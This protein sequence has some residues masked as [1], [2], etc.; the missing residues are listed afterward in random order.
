M[1][2]SELRD[3]VR[4]Y[5]HDPSTAPNNV[6]SDSEIN[7][8]LDR[9]YREVASKIARPLPGW[10]TDFE[11]LNSVTTETYTIPS[12]TVK[13]LQVRVD[14]DG[15]DLSATP[16]SD[17]A[18]VLDFVT[19]LM[20]NTIRAEGSAAARVWT[21]VGNT[22]YIVPVFTTT[23][24][25]SVELQRLYLPTSMAA[26]TSSPAFPAAHHDI[27]VTKG[28]VLCKQA[29]QQDW[30]GDAQLYQDQLMNL[31]T[32]LHSF[33]AGEYDQFRTQAFDSPNYYR[34]GE[35]GVSKQGTHGRD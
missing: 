35:R 4:F 18:T 7:N 6:W 14:T 1:T 23:G 21:V 5:L 19:P 32:D 26:D 33:H 3:E 13:I 29:R 20:L 15:N 34:V 10:F 17:A 11:Y 25:N 8:A 28:V 12:D 30:T 2:R 22:L 27:L 16:S 31:L 24:T 9:A